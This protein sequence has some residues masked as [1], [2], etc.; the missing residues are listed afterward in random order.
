M[1]MYIDAAGRGACRISNHAVMHV[2]PWLYM[3]HPTVWKPCSS[4][5]AQWIV[6]TRL[7]SRRESIKVCCSYTDVRLAIGFTQAKC[8]KL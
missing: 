3:I 6:T 1:Y 2:Y 8:C 4:W 5:V 7:S